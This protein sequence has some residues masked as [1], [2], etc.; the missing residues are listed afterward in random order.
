MVKK[1]CK[2]CGKEYETSK[3]AASAPY[4]YCGKKCEQEAK[5]KR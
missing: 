5:G 4:S 1:T 3:S 2:W